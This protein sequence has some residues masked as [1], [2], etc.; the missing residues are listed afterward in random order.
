MRDGRS[1]VAERRQQED[2]HAERAA[3]IQ[4]SE[5]ELLRR[6]SQMKRDLEEQARKLE[7]KRRQFDEE[8][9]RFEAVRHRRL[10]CSPPTPPRPRP[11]AAPLSPRTARC[12]SA[13]L[14][15]AP[16]P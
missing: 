12:C 11:R 1:E 14:R 10:S 5:A 13:L 7:E 2:A 16:A 15:F 8:R 9:K 4:D 3:A 6:H